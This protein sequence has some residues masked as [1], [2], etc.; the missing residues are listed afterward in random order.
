MY[1]P[2]ARCL[3]LVIFIDD[4]AVI[5]LMNYGTYCRQSLAEKSPFNVLY[6]ALY[7]LWLIVLF[8]SVFYHQCDAMHSAV[9][10][11]SLLYCFILC[12]LR[13]LGFVL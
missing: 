6:V 12:C 11:V 7:F 8:F 10:A 13:F 9:S 2:V 4:D 1:H 5:W 3:V